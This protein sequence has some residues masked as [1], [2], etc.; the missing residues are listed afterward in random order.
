M[1]STVP[2]FLEEFALN[3]SIKSRQDLLKTL[4]PGSKDSVYYESLVLL[5]RL[6]ELL[7]KKNLDWSNVP[8]S[9]NEE[10]S[11]LFEDVKKKITEGS[12]KNYPEIDQQLKMRF[13]L[14]AYPID[15]T[16]TCN[17]LMQHFGLEK[18]DL[19]A[20]ENILLGSDTADESSD[21]GNQLPS[22][23]DVNHFNDSRI[24]KLIQNVYSQRLMDGNDCF[25]PIA[26]PFLYQL[27]S[28]S[29]FE[30]RTIIRY[31]LDH[32]KN[33]PIR[34]PDF[35]KRL[36]KVIMSSK[37]DQNEQVESVIRL[38]ISS[39]TLAQMDELSEYV[40]G[41]LD[42]AN[43]IE[44][45]L[46]KLQPTSDYF[47]E[48]A[49]D[50]TVSDDVILS[51]VDKALEFLQ[52]VPTGGEEW[53]RKAM[54][55]KLTLNMFR[56]V[57]DEHLFLNYLRMPRRKRSSTI[58]DPQFGYERRNASVD[59][60]LA[61]SGNVRPFIL[62]SPELDES[63]L[64]FEYLSV[65]FV[66]G[67]SKDTFQ[68]ILDFQSYLNPIHAEAMFTAGKIQ[69][70]DCIA[71]LGQTKFESLVEQQD[72]EFTPNSKR[73]KIWSPDE[74]IEISLR[75]KN[76]S[77]L[78]IRVFQI[79]MYSYYRKH[80]K[81][82]NVDPNIDLDGLTPIWESY[83]T[84]NDRHASERYEETFQFS[85][86]NGLANKEF[87]GR[88]LW[89]ID[90]I[91]GR[92]S[93]RALVQKGF[94]NCIIRPT[95][96]GQLL[97]LSDEE[98]RKLDSHY[99]V[100][101]AGK[102]LESDP[103]GNIMIPFSDEHEDRQML[104]KL[105]NYAQVVSA[106]S[107]IEKYAFDASFYVNHESL[108]KER[109]ATITVIPFL[110]VGG[111]RA[112]L[113][114]LEDMRLILQSFDTSGISSS[115][116]LA[117]IKF[118]ENQPCKNEFRV[119]PDLRILS[120]TVEGK[121]KRCTGKE[122][123]QDISATYSLSLDRE[124]HDCT[125]AYIQSNENGYSLYLTGKNGEPK[126]KTAV[127]MEL[128]HKFFTTNIPVM[129][130]TEDNGEIR[131]GPLSNITQLD[132]PM[133]NQRMEIKLD[134]QVN[135]WP[136]SIF[137]SQGTEI[138]LPF[139]SGEQY[140][141][142]LGKCGVDQLLIEDWTDNVT[143]A[144][145][146]LKISGLS[147]GQYHLQCIMSKY[148]LSVKLFIIEDSKQP[149]TE[150]FWTNFRLGKRWAVESP[151]NSV[152]RPLTISQVSRQAERV[153][154]QLQNW[155]NKTYAIVCGTTTLSHRMVYENFMSRA[156]K[157]QL[158][159]WPVGQCAINT[160]F[161][162]GRKLSEEY[163]YILERARYEKW[164]G[165]TLQQ[166]SLLLKRQEQSQTS[167]ANK[168]EKGAVGFEARPKQSRNVHNRMFYRPGPYGKDSFIHEYNLT[169]V[170]DFLDIQNIETN[171]VKPDQHGCIIIEMSS[172]GTTSDLSILV[173][174]GEQ[175][176]ARDIPLF[177]QTDIPK[178]DLRHFSPVDEGKAI[179][180]AREI[181]KLAATN[182]PLEAWVGQEREVVDNFEKLF[183]L[184]ETASQSE[185]FKTFAFMAT[186]TKL[187]YE[188]KLEIYNKHSCHELNFWLMHKDKTFFKNVV[189]VALKSKIQ[190]TFLDLYLLENDISAFATDL[191][192][193]NSLNLVEKVLLAKR[194]PAIHH[195]VERIITEY[196][197]KYPNES[198]KLQQQ[199]DT[200]LAGASMD[201][202]KYT[203]VKA[204]LPMPMSAPG[205][206][207]P[208]ASTGTRGFGSSNSFVAES[209]TVQGTSFGS[210]M[211]A[212]LSA[213]LPID[214]VLER[215]E[216]LD[217]SS[218]WAG[219]SGNG[220]QQDVTQ[221][222][223]VMELDDIED[224][225]GDEEA[226]MESRKQLSSEFRYQYKERTREYCETN[227]L[228]E[229]IAI[230]G[231]GF[232]LDYL[233]HASSE[234]FLSERFMQASHSFTEQ[235]LAMAVMELPFK[236]DAKTSS[237][238]LSEHNQIK[239]TASTPA[240]VF[241]RSLKLCEVS[242]KEENLLVVQNIFN[243]SKYTAQQ[244]KRVHV[245]GEDLKKS[246]EYGIHVV[247]SNMTAETFVIEVSYQIPIGSVPTR[248]SKYLDAIPI[249]IEPFTTWQEETSFFY[250][251]ENGKYTNVPVSVTVGGELVARSK[252]ME[253]EVKEE[254]Q[255]GERADWG[256]IASH[257]D[258][259]NVI[260]YLKS[261]DLQGIDFSLIY[262]KMEN[263]SFAT[264]VISILRGRKFYDFNLWCYGIKHNLPLAIRDILRIDEHSLSLVGRYF[265]SALV[266]L[267]DDSRESLKFLDY[268]PIIKARGN[269]LETVY[270]IIYGRY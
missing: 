6:D 167:I 31:V 164:T 22:S 47:A 223:S 231:N 171:I 229:N 165:T 180:R 39:L 227:Y 166:P 71:V 140:Y 64:T 251:P 238:F 84:Y 160:L 242:T 125:N 3:D 116:T 226:L 19:S 112:P 86:P 189:Q 139:H 154:I 215:G 9:L 91:S 254:T 206:E 101:V 259:K 153:K 199:F 241:H 191:Y 137:E 250:F 105:Q 37:E 25:E 122:K 55:K 74:K 235:M 255:D 45:Y 51:Y 190:K 195:S 149:S 61:S 157:R 128:K 212:A 109:I 33:T 172:L 174:S 204:M 110:K 245:T 208:G 230:A 115:Y 201:L 66:R 134:E 92:K 107:L 73:S 70:Q 18:H 182:T 188:G 177:R 94:I 89:V 192:K 243:A 60:W 81:R 93:C 247:I 184:F 130:K 176:V 103:S 77:D 178:I 56:G 197:D 151:G 136:E 269:S 163:Q 186:W 14:L 23:L 135:N 270:F 108:Q 237:Q 196:L 75:L 179:V 145:G 104:F 68:G 240:L 169:P 211:Y 170:Y 219:N 113:S 48:A 222:D 32:A 146:F 69:A 27:P 239:V 127:S 41:I 85:G 257:G 119:P 50:H 53:K 65:L 90:F 138:K 210:S 118:E 217:S 15:P 209:A 80:P 203:E 233:R 16:L 7:Q 142:S 193:F 133:V 258:Q 129:L 224:S 143:I 232:W 76:V 263:R 114:L 24:G 162:S 225:D 202:K 40:S 244:N 63:S 58:F 87:E 88:G 44:L 100:F 264:D 183:T 207:M 78:G 131:L 106:K 205:P 220:N 228:S 12:T 67:L 181:T 96:S 262:N 213:P 57:Y 265:R 216:R 36:S 159:K 256:T 249:R 175:A 120:F 161:V 10:E 99:S 221:E 246:V 29:D 35:V 267:P 248:S 214:S 11:L 4:V 54:H 17:H 185:D 13:Q 28:R 152:L 260:E 49:V 168:T 79:N 155:S 141:V 194:I 42:D 266:D 5:Q 62:S 187:S 173:V 38:D 46:S 34:L 200:V 148:V 95:V 26:L 102:E 156:E 117:D 253:L 198:S 1:T 144:D 97:T 252:F 126:R 218:L 30:E 8:I 158:L 82:Q 52:K 2:R 21:S 147:P 132:L 234:P 59:Y 43:Y 83:K 236:G 150:Q 268:S 121:V 72:F 111:Q 20:D 261:G 124:D 123:Y 98:N